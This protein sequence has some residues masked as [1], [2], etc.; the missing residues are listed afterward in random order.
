MLHSCAYSGDARYI[1]RETP[2]V[3]HEGGFN[4]TQFVVIDDKLLNEISV[5]HRV[6]ELSHWSPNVQ[7]KVL[8]VKWNIC[9]DSFFF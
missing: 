5:E 4:L 2:K 8:G 3:L 6:K 9:S 7:G 1:I